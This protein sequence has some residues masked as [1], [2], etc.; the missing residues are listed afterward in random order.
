[1]YDIV[2][3]TWV[4]W[5]MG[6]VVTSLVLFGSPV[7]YKRL[8]KR[9]RLRQ[10]SKEEDLPWEAFFALLEK[11]NRERAEAGLPPEEPT[12]EE[13]SQLLA[14]LPDNPLVQS[15]KDYEFV[16]AGGGDDK[17]SSGRRWGNPTSVRLDNDLHGLVVN[18]SSGGIGI[19]ADREI[20]PGTWVSVKAAEAPFDVSAVHAEVRHCRK[21]G[22]GF[23]LGCKFL[24]DVPWQVRVWFG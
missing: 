14:S 12:S 22:K 9:D 8:R 1:L 20:A 24:G 4:A 18:R 11:R 3:T 21:V 16:A 13:L 17:R 7:L 10:D 5:G 6:L 15:E 23:F 19:F 2:W